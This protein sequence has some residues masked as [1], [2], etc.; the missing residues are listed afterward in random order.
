MNKSFFRELFVKSQVICEIL[1]KCSCFW[2][3]QWQ[4]LPVKLI[5]KAL[6]L[7]CDIGKCFIQKCLINGATLINASL[8]GL[9]FKCSYWMKEWWQTGSKISGVS[10]KKDVSSW[11]VYL[12]LYA[13]VSEMSL[14]KGNCIMGMERVIQG[15]LED[16]CNLRKKL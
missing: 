16:Y 15:D 12:V 13:L 10:S 3:N 11:P 6:F 8:M 7:L 2:Q 14:K 4:E 9:H 1:M 5:W